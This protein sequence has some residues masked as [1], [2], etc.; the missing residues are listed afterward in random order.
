MLDIKFIRENKDVVALA[1]KNKNRT[2]DLDVLI[3]LYDKKKAITQKLDELNR[4]RNEASNNRNIEKGTLLKK[5]SEEIEKEP[6]GGTA[7]NPQTNNR[8]LA[9]ENWRC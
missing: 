5:E 4:K 3:G 9:G 2:L 6:Q 1:I 7:P 8:S